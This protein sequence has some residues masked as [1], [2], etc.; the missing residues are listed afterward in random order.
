VVMVRMKF[1]ETLREATTFIE[2]GH[3]RVG[4]EVTVRYMIAAAA[5]I[6]AIARATVATAVAGAS[7]ANEK[8][9]CESVRSCL[10]PSVRPW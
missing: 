10:L 9:A 8:H 5:H 7:A 1:A 3:V 4:P 2:Q 6:A